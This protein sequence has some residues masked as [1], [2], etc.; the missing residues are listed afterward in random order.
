MF[1]LAQ[2]LMSTESLAALEDG[3]II[4]ARPAA[5]YAEGHISGAIHLSA[6]DLAEERDGKPGMLR[7]VQDVARELFAAGVDPRKIVV[8][9]ADMKSAGEMKDATRLFW[10]LEY[11]GYPRVAVLDGGYQKWMSEGHAVSKDTVTL[12][13]V[14]SHQLLLR[15]DRLATQADVAAMLGSGEGK[16]V[17]LRSEASYS[18]ADKK[19]FVA[20][21]GHIPNAANVPA[22]ALLE[23]ELN[24]VKSADALRGLMKDAGVPMDAP[25]VNYCNTGRSASVGYFVG[26]LLG[27]EQVSLYDG[28]MAEWGN[29]TAGDVQTGAPKKD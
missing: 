25:M 16:A 26:R 17:D 19:G 3:I 10:I 1:A 14:S 23:G 2:L 21:G 5:L 20:H 11:L 8:V 29:L 28:S 12:D 13:S 6:S 7:P 9:Y 22:S 18:G 15:L 4:D 24:T 27:H